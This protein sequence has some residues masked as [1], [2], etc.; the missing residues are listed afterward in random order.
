[1]R[2]EIFVDESAHHVVYFVGFGIESVVNVEEEDRTCIDRCS[3][4]DFFGFFDFK[5]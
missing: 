4:D 1:M 2:G 3:H 5:A